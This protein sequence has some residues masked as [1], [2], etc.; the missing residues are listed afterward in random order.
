MMHG[1]GAIAMF[2]QQEAMDRILTFHEVGY[3]TW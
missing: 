3:I 1:Q 2:D